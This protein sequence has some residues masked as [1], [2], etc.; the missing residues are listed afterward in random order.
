MSYEYF[1]YMYSTIIYSITINIP[2]E[3][4]GWDIFIYSYSINNIKIGNC[5]GERLLVKECNTQKC[6]ANILKETSIIT[7]LEE[8]K[9]VKAFNNNYNSSNINNDEIALNVTFSLKEA[10]NNLNRK[11]IR[12]Y[13]WM[14]KPYMNSLNKL[15]L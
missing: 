8:I 4:H 3:S 9:K 11:R 2:L 14:I 13:S 5:I 15:L 6:P 12:Y 7:E 10:Q 1:K